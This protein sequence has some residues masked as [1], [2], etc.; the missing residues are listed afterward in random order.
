MICNDLFLKMICSYNLKKID[1]KLRVVKLITTNNSLK[2]GPFH[3]R[4]ISSRKPTI[5]HD[6]ITFNLIIDHPL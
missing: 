6:K 3:N 1:F 2:G 4:S 5:A